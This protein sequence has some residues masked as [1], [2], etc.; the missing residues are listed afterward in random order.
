MLDPKHEKK[1]PP[2]ILR[3]K[4]FPKHFLTRLR[5]LSSAFTVAPKRLHSC[6]GFSL[7]KSKKKRS[8][9]SALRQL[10]PVGRRQPCSQVA[11]SGRPCPDQS[12]QYCTHCCTPQ[13]CHDL[14]KRCTGPVDGYRY[15]F[16]HMLRHSTCASQCVIVC[17]QAQHVRKAVCDCMLSG[18]ARVRVSVI[19]C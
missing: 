15:L 18:T 8:R 16:L 6:T 9:L 3:Q 10:G 19:V 12:L 17:C 11:C 7:S 4:K 2:K 14:R 5:R 1:R 13:S